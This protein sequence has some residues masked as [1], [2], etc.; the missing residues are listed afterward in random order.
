MENSNTKRV[1]PEKSRK[2]KQYKEGKHILEKA[3]E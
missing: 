3:R 2:K 1:T